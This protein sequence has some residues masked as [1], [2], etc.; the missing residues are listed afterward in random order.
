[1][2]GRSARRR[3]RWRSRGE[4]WSLLILR[5]AAFAGVPRFAVFQQRLGI[6]PN[7][8]AARLELFVVED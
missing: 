1:M 3:A 4:R 5:N 7:V 8:L 6:A 2:I